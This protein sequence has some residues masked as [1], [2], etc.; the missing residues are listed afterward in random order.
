MGGEL[1]V[2]SSP[3]S[4]SAFSFAI[5]AP[6]TAY[7]PVSADDRSL[8]PISWKRQPHVLLVEDN[9]VNREV[10]TA[11]LK[12][13]GCLPEAVEDGLQ[14]VEA[15]CMKK[16]DLLLMD[17]Q[18]PVMDG[19]EATRKIRSMD[20]GTHSLA[21]I[22]LTAHIT[23]QDRE[24][25]FEAGM[26][27]YLGKPFK[28]ETLR[29]ILCKW[30]S[31]LLA[32]S[33]AAGHAGSRSDEDLPLDCPISTHDRTSIHDLRNMLSGIIGGL[34]LAMLSVKSPEK[35]EEYLRTALKSARQAV[36]ISK[37]L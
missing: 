10:A 29:F 2:T 1:T 13:L 30:L 18:M 37:T 5:A 11:Y 35:S 17:C 6:L 27:D 3:G 15:C 25:C 24:R 7:T 12:R 23:A 16:Y 31:H 28:I 33:A 20:D 8:N 26:N 32:T 14:A 9:E 36:K 22:A 4:G 34:E 21:I 19:Y